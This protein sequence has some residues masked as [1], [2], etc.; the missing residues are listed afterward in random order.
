MTKLYSLFGGTTTDTEVKAVEV[1]QVVQMQGYSYDC[2]VV[3]KI[4]HDD[5]FGYRYHLIN[6]RTLDIHQSEIIKPLS[7][8]FGIGM[9]Y[10]ENNIEFMPEKETAELLAKAQANRVDKME[11][12]RAEEKRREEVRVIGRDWLEKNLPKDAQALI[13]ACLKQ[14]ESDSQT[15]YFASSTVRTV[16]LG[17][18]KHQ[19]DIFSEMRKY[20][21]NF[22]ET[23]YLF[24]YNE[25]YEHREKY[26]MGKGYYLGESYYHGWIIKKVPIYN[27]ES[28]IKEFAYTAG[29]PDNIHIKTT[30]RK[31][32]T[33]SGGQAGEMQA[34]QRADNLRFEIVD[35]SEKA[36]ALFGDTKEIKDLLK[37]MGG[38]FNPRLTHNNEK[39]AGWIFSQTKRKELERVLNLNK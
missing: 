25:N 35:Y 17:F 4:T 10:D 33:V 14:D 19:R 27:R 20:A 28:T 16:I 1:N 18:S 30:G 31:N 34:V 6:L 9:Y 3:Y 37:A 11:K 13:V 8:K 32:T 2:Y 29:N 36:I 5:K 24:E 26:S 15:D 38:K 12:E 39:Q 7:Q 23:A 21:S 22:E